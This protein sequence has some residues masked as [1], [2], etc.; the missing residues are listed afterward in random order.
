LLPTLSALATEKN[1]S[2]FRGTLRHGLGTL[3]F[4]NFIAAIL[5]VVLAEP[6]VRLIFEH[7]KFTSESTDRAAFALMCL[8]PGL[9]AFSSVNILVRAFFAL[10]DTQT[11]MKI[12]LA[13][14]VLNIL[15]AAAL[16]VPLRQGG[17]G[18]ANTVT[19]VCNVCLLVFA[20]RKKLGKLEMESLS[21]TFLPLAAAGAVAGL[22]AWFGWQF[23]ESRIGHQTIALK[24]GAV[25][26]PAGIAGMV[27]WL[28]A[29]A[30]KIPAAKEVTE[31]ALAKFKR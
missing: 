2:E 11:P 27:Y 6:I 3:L 28:M 16:V 25:F 18:I 14:L 29:L 12:S 5:L 4:L 24:I 17:L 8:A 21:A 19:S 15:L 31:F 20:L 1:Y 30:F 23:W 13:S 7:G 9:V 26:A 22:I 10:G